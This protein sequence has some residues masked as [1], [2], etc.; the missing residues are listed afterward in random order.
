MSHFSL[1]DPV[2]DPKDYESEYYGDKPLAKH[3][4][5]YDNSGHMSSAERPAK[6][7]GVLESQK[8]GHGQSYPGR[9]LPPTQTVKT[10]EVVKGAAIKAARKQVGDNRLP[11][12]S[13]IRDKKEF[14]P[15]N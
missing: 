11:L 3:S 8:E 4:P 10:A 14:G 9:A 2:G 1:S 6:S 5:S 15:N 12:N 7:G 13:H